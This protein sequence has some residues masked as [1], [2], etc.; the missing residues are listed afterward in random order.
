MSSRALILCVLWIGTTTVAAT[1]A[2]ELCQGVVSGPLETQLQSGNVSAV[3]CNFNISELACLSSTNFTNL[4]S[5]DLATLL[6]CKLPSSALYTKEIWVLFLKKF[7]T[8][9]DAVL[10][11]F[12][13]V[14]LNITGS[15]SNILDAIGEVMFSNFNTTDLANASLITK[16]FQSRLRPFLSSVSTAFLGSLGAKNFS[17]QTFQIVM[18]VFSTQEMAMMEEQKWSV[19]R[20]FTYPFLLAQQTQGQSCVQSLSNDSDW[21]AKNFGKF[22]KF[23]SLSDFISLKSDFNGLNATEVLTPSQLAELCSEP[24]RLRGPQD[25]NRVMA[26]IN[27][28]QFASFFN[29]LSPNIQ[30]NESRYSSDLKKAFLQNILQRGGLSSAPLNDSE[31]LQWVN[32]LL[33][34]FLSSLSSADVTPYFNIIRNQTCNTSQIAISKLD[35]LRSA[36]SNDTQVQIRNNIQQLFAEPNG[37]RCYSGGSFFVF[38]KSFFLS[39]GFPDLSGVLSIIP[40]SRQK[41]LLDSISPGELRQFLNGTN[42]VGNG[43]DLCTFLN[44]YNRTNQYLEKEPVVSAAVGRQT[45]ACVWPRALSASSQDEVDQWFNV[46]LGRYLPFLSSQLINSTQLSN[47]SCLSYR[48]LVSFLGNN[49]NFTSTDFTPADVYSSMKSYLKSSDG[50]PRC[51]NSSDPL[52]NSSAWFADNIGFFITFI[53]LTDL[54]SYVSESK[55]N[56]FLENIFNLQLFNNTAITASVTKYFSSQL[57]ILNPSFNL[58]SLPPVLLCGVPGSAFVS[59]GSNAIQTFLTNINNFCSDTNPE[60]AAVLVSKVTNF[61]SGFIEKLGK[62]VV[63]LSV[64]Q[65]TTVDV[66]VIKSSLSSLS[67]VT[68][69]D[70]GQAKA[71]VKK[72]TSAGFDFSVGSSL[73]KLGTLIGG[74]PSAIIS[75]M[76]STELLNAVKDSTFIT[77]ILSAPVILQ[78][79]CIQQIVSADPLKIL[80]NVPD[81][82]ASYIPSV[83]LTSFSSLNVQ[84]LNKKIWRPEQAVLFM[85]QVASSFGNLEDLSESVLQGFTASSIKTLSVQKIKQLVKACRPRS[86]RSK[87]V[88]KESQLT[89]MY[90]MIKDDTSLAFAD[91][92]SDMLLYY[93]YDK[94]QTGSCRSY[95]SALGS[96]DF[97]V[98]S[99]VLNKQSVLFSNAQSCLGISGYK[100]TKDQ[101]GVLGNMICTLDAAYI[102]NSDPSILEYLKNCTDLSSAQ[103]TAVQTLLTSGST[104][105]GIPSVWTQQTLE[106]LGGLSLYL[107]QDFWA[108]F[109]TSLKKRFLKY[110][111]PILR[112]QKVSVEKMR[113]FF[114]A[115]TYKRVAREATRAGCTVGNITAVTISDDSFPMDYDSAQFDACLDSSFLTYNLAG[116]TQKVLDTS[117]QTII[118]NKLKQLYPS[119]LPESEVQ[120]L[121]STSRM[122]SAADIS[123]WNITTT[124]TLSS[125]LDSTYGVWTSDQSKAVIMRYL[126]VTGNT[127]GTAELNIIGSSVC[128]L[129]V[130][131]LKNITADS[132]KSANALNLTNCSVDQKTTLYTIANSSYYSQRSVSSTFYQLISSYLGGAPLAD[133]QTLSSMN[134]SMDIATFRSLKTAVLEALSV[135]TV[136]DLLGVNL[137]DLKLFENSTEVQTWVAQ[138]TKADLATLGLG[139]VGGKDTVATASA[140]V[141]TQ[142]VAA[143]GP[144]VVHGV[145]GPW[146]FT[147]FVGLLM[148]TL[149]ILQ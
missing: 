44:N 101:V 35:S 118:L 40:G 108:S 138:Q 130:S 11:N 76:P 38:L 4:T 33:S 29:Q 72:I 10:D 68:G 132:L 123:Q 95:F 75:K 22:S 96:A 116:L 140:T 125:L 133:I 52:L 21:L 14:T 90:N 83:L 36:F 124:D 43:S 142:T 58:S 60:V 94:V 12:S 112:T 19:V 139:L 126:S 18:E 147:M 89:L 46:R 102:Q 85:S 141:A 93:N 57:F 37:L 9:L 50:S 105:Y 7:A 110:Y 23:A 55:M 65:I 39:F 74:L 129:D 128:S 122:A 88:L 71:L 66:N 149:Q 31:V 8:S 120:L 134:I 28:N 143:H 73:V 84:L 104:S 51:Y 17:C 69:W 27:P 92:P 136:H 6:T 48:K 107:K 82:L 15:K 5:G 119:G 135:G 53:T 20:N 103:V 56:T 13:N 127:L 98:L 54:Q 3:I 25:V 81:K 24:S 26:A 63:G 113:L 137:P 64:S 41:E 1:N 148:I 87:V 45:L 106:Q 32:V 61:T 131:V 121:G 70:P 91:L 100:L 49:Y 145:S 78:Q 79:T 30:K 114:T 86:G 34:P 117:L 59:S 2:T 16:W 146:F 42:T 115:F 144:G 62:Q 77:N 67:N 97:S 109:G 111:M 47:A 99:S 80:D